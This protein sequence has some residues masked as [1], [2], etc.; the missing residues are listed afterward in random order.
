ADAAATAAGVTLSL[1][2]HRVYVLPSNVACGWAGYGQIGCGSNCW[3][4]IAT[5]DR[6]DVYAHELGHNLGMYHSSFDTNDDGV[7]DS[8]CPWGAWSGGGEYCDGS[9]IMGISTNVWRTMN[10]AHKDQMGWIPSAKVVDVATSGTY[11]VAPLE[12]APSATTLPLVL[13][14]ARPS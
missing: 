13:R 1:Y 6:G 8:T 5:C 4:M 2:Q 12:T 7:V 9:D 3:A 10:G 14:V 11:A